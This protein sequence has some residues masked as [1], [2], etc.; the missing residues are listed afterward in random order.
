MHRWPPACQTAAHCTERAVESS[1]R[2]APVHTA[3]PAAGHI[4]RRVLCLPRRRTYH[5]VSGGCRPPSDW[6]ERSATGAG[7]RTPRRPT[8]CR[9]YCRKNDRA[10]DARRREDPFG[11]LA[12]DH[13]LAPFAIFLREPPSVV[14]R[15]RL[16]HQR[17]GKDRK[18]LR[19]RSLLAGHVARGRRSL[20]HAKDRLAGFTVQQK[21][22]PSLRSHRDSR[23]LLALAPDGEQRGLRRDVVV[24]QIVMHG[25]KMPRHLASVRVQRYQAIG[26][27]VVARTLAA[28][29]IRATTSM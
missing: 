17:L 13:F 16:R 11:A 8:P 22:V 29:V 26:I 2:C 27:E 7:D 24:P 15:E 5:A 3:C 25:L 4:R 9:R 19:G 18:R 10:V 23:H 6:S 14:R 1:A 28:I 12:A 21:Q 20:L